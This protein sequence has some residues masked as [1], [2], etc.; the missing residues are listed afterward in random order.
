MKIQSFGLSLA[1][2]SLTV[3]AIGLLPSGCRP[4]DP[5]QRTDLSGKI[6]LDGVPVDSGEIILIP[7]KERGNSGPAVVAPITQGTY[8]SMAPNGPVAGPAVAQIYGYASPRVSK[9]SDGVPALV[10][11]SYEVQIEIPEKKGVVDF[12]LTK[13]QIKKK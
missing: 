3:L 12:E 6:T 1:A 5:Y 11:D 7:D 8:R 2:T 10:I 4:K 13:D 9:S